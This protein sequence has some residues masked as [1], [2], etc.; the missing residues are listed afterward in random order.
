FINIPLV[1]LS[2]GGLLLF[3]HEDVE[4]RRHKIDYAGSL[5]LITG[6]STFLVFLLEGGDSWEWVSAPS[7]G[8]ITVALICAAAF[9]RHEDRT[10]EPLLPLSLFRNRMIAV[11]NLATLVTGVL[12]IGVSANIPN[13]V[14][15]VGGESATIAGLSLGAM[16][17]GWPIASII[18][19]RLLVV[20]GFRFTALLGAPPLILSSLWLVTFNEGTPPPEVAGATFVM[21]LG[22][23]FTSTSFIVMVQQA[24]EWSQRGVVTSANM[25]MRQIGSALGVAVLGALINSQVKAVE[26]AG[27][28]RSITTDALLDEDRRRTLSPEV[29]DRLSAYLTDGL[30]LVFLGLLA[31]AVFG[32]LIML[33]LPKMETPASSQRQAKAAPAGQRS[34]WS[35]FRL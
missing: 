6:T 3:L 25:F 8:L 21:G 19:G 23:G 22:L 1:L 33:L 26:I 17:L 20:K 24:V 10:P 13:F 9:I 14:Q 15:G 30:H 34:A 7:L 11:V 35:R 27:G 18:A 28:A 5:L 16:S 2:I 31:T 4:K 12:T 29:I 32:A